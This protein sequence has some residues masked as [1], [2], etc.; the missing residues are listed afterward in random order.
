VN[1]L[2]RI[3]DVKRKAY[4]GAAGARRKQFCNE[5]SRVLRQI[6][7]DI[8]A[9]AKNNLKE[10]EFISCGKGCSFCCYQHLGVTFAHGLLVV[11]HL[12]S[13]ERELEIFLNNFPGWRERVGG[14]SDEIDRDFRLAAQNPD[15]NELLN[16]VKSPLFQTYHEN[17]VPCPFLHNSVC[18]IY[19]V[20]PSGCV[21]HISISPADRCAK[22]SPFK[23]NTK[24]IPI[25]ESDNAK[26]LSLPYGSPILM[27]S[28][29]TLPT[30]TYKLLVNGLPHFSIETGTGR[31]FV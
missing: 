5:Y 20:R 16:V 30:M 27:L 21:Q 9:T 10:G 1:E 12:Y 13:H 3:K 25:K 24:E 6:H 17:Q 2:A 14:I 23:P 8:L 15:P 22:N 26:L 11:D 31:I 18:S 29:F 28:I 7:T 4:L 19:E